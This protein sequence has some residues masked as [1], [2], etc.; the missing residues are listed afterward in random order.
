[1]DTND[2]GCYNTEDAYVPA[3][4]TTK[5]TDTKH[6]KEYSTIGKAYQGSSGY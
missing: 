4:L 3:V 2:T 5:I 1:M 6:G